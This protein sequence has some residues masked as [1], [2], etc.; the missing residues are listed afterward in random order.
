MLSFMD[1]FS[2]YHQIL[3]HLWDQEHTSFVTNKG[4]DYYTSKPFGLKNAWATFQRLVNKI[5]KD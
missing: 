3:M 1:A 5:F 2:G 4:T